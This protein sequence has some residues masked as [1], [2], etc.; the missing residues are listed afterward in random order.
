[1]VTIL[2]V[3]D[4]RR[5]RDAVHQ[6]LKTRPD[7]HVVGEAADGLEAVKQAEKLRPD[8]ILLDVGL[9]KLSGLDAARRILNSQS[10]S[11]IL[12]FSSD[13]SKPLVEE[14]FRLGASGYFAKMGNGGV[15]PPPTNNIDRLLFFIA[16]KALFGDDVGFR[17][18]HDGA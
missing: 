11:K 3:D 4:F 12:F 7:L 13:F 8:L 15:K 2:I 1:M 14:A 18:G 17:V 10:G 9:P 5:F 6:I 16:V